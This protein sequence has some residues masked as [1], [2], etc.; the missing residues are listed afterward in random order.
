MLCSFFITQYYNPTPGD[1]TEQAKVDFED[2]NISLD[3]ESIRKGSKK[4]FKNVVKIKSEE[5]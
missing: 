5:Y 3:F 2:F 4:S 1:W